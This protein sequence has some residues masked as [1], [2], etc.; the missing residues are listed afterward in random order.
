ME[1]ELANHPLFSL[2]DEVGLLNGRF[3]SAF[4]AVRKSV[5]LGETEMTVLNSVIQAE[6]PPTVAQIGRSLGIARQLVQRAANM[7]KAQGLVELLPNPDHK[8]ALLLVGTAKGRAIKAE[9]D[10][11]GKAIVERLDEGFDL[12]AVRE[13]ARQLRNIRKALEDQ[14]RSGG[15]G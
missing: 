9:A 15:F 8:R 2:V 3:K 10:T 5:H 11:A 14:L 6:R 13:T 1:T 7:L 12:Q 4:A